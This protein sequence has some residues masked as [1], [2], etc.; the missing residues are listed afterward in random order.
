MK[1]ELNFREDVTPDE[2]SEAL[3]L[4]ENYSSLGGDS[5]YITGVRHATDDDFLVNMHLSSDFDI[6]GLSEKEQINSTL[7]FWEHLDCGELI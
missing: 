4:F 2:L 6:N 1:N 7:E 5:E 3:E